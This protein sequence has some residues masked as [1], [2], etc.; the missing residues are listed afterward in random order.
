MMLTLTLALAVLFFITTV[1]YA[2]LLL[3]ERRLNDDLAQRLAQLR[4]DHAL[5]QRA[6]RIVAAKNLAH[7][8]GGIEGEH[9]KT[10][11]ID[12]MVRLLAGPDYDQWV[13]DQKAGEDGPNTYSWDEGIPP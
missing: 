2:R 3:R 6:E 9:H 11:V 7:R 12:Q 4:Q 8:Y 10:W 5:G 13:T 1:G